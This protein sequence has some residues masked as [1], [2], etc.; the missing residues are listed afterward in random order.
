MLAWVGSRFDPS[1]QS[2]SSIELRE[3]D[4]AAF[5]CAASRLDAMR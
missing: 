3:S 1:G 5:H 2:F 4:A